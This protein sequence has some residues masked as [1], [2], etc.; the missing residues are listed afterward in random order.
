MTDP[1]PLPSAWPC[2]ER[3][4]QK[5]HAAKMATAPETVEPCQDCP[6]PEDEADGH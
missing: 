3:A 5:A 1:E 4:A 2:G 6:E